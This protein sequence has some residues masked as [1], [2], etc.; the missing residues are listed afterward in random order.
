MG[1]AESKPH[2][3]TNTINEALETYRRLIALNKGGKRVNILIVGDPKCGKSSF[4][5]T[6]YKILQKSTFLVPVTDIGQGQ[7]GG[8]ET[9]Y[10]RHVDTGVGVHLYDCPGFNHGIR[11]WQGAMKA[12]IEGLKE[13]TKMIERTMEGFFDLSKLPNTHEPKNAINFAIFLINATN[14]TNEVPGWFRD[15]NVVDPDRGLLSYKNIYDAID[16][17]LKKRTLGP[18]PPFHH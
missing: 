13:G 17:E 7:I 6:I 4:I 14:S 12:M 16:K 15:Y 9:I 5:C 2:A 18:M 3:D 8:C 11:G 10:Y 1:A